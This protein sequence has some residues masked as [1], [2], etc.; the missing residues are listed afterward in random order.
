M[1]TI[2]K[3]KCKIN[4]FLT[5][6]LQ[7]IKNHVV[8]HIFRARFRARSMFERMAIILSSIASAEEIRVSFILFSAIFSGKI[9]VV[10]KSFYKFTIRILSFHL[11]E[12]PQN[13]PKSVYRQ[14]QNI[15]GYQHL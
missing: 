9:G 14:A 2:L 15:G 10:S 3:H 13:D 11:S 5:I 1:Q 8:K 12:D 7:H 4:I 6:F